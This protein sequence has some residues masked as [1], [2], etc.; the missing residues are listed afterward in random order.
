MKARPLRYVGGLI[1]G[2]GLSVHAAYAA[3][4]ACECPAG[5]VCGVEGGCISECQPRCGQSEQ[6]EAQQ[7]VPGPPVSTPLRAHLVIAGGWTVQVAPSLQ[8]ALFGPNLVLHVE[9]GDEHRVFVG[10][11]VA[12]L[13]AAVGPP[14]CTGPCPADRGSAGPT[15]EIGLDLGY[16]ARFGSGLV[17]AGPIVGG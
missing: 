12:V 14:L 10:P 7:C 9:L 6:C 1:L 2:L 4:S 16:R 3:P 8:A 13:L 17:K 5:F 11:R 15:A